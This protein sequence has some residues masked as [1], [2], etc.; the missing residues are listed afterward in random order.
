[1]ASGR[2]P[3]AAE[4][5]RAGRSILLLLGANGNK[6]LIFKA[7]KNQKGRSE[8]KKAGIYKL[9][10]KGRFIDAGEGGADAE[11]LRKNGSSPPFIWP[12]K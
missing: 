1:M 4:I 7:R 11:F 8:N 2:P 12:G 9:L 10:G 6:K 5:K 3:A